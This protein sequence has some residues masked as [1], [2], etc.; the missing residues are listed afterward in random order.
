MPFHIVRPTLDARIAL[1]D[2]GAELFVFPDKADAPPRGP[3]LGSARDIIKFHSSRPQFVNSAR[4]LR[5]AFARMHFVF[6]AIGI[7]RLLC[8]KGT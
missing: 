5:P 7:P 1:H 3:G 2:S 8:L 4:A 6:V